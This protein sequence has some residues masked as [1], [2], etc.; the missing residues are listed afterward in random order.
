MLGIRIA[1][2]FSF[3]LARLEQICCPLLNVF[4]KQKP[5]W[6]FLCEPV[7]LVMVLFFLFWDFRQLET[8][9]FLCA[10]TGG[11]FCQNKK[12]EYSATNY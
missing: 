2:L 3:P 6:L 9:L 4:S 1:C 8:V 12:T 10:N 7:F 11:E 5:I